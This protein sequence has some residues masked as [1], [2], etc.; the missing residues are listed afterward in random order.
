MKSN[1]KTDT[2]RCPIDPENLFNLREIVKNVKPLNDFIGDIAQFSLV[3]DTNYI[4]GDLIW[5]T[6]K[7]KYPT[8]KT[9]VQEC[10]LAG[11]FIVFCTKTVIDEVNE[12][13]AVVA[14]KHGISINLIRKE[15]ELYQSM[16]RVKQ[17][18]NEITDKYNNGVDPDDAPT[19]ALAEQLSAEGILSKDRHINMMGG[20]TISFDFCASARDYSRKATISVTLRI[21]GMYSVVIGVKLF[22]GLYS[23]IKSIA[24]WIEGLPNW[25]KILLIAGILIAFFLAKFREYIFNIINKLISIIKESFPSIFEVLNQIIIILK[26]NEPVAP[27]IN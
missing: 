22:K 13:L 26:E 4:I 10:I 15:W 16:L 25:A 11:T 6:K 5:L 9:E 8:A 19:L 17:P 12:K 18:D 1:K 2:R 24:A 27:I 7:R 3:I 14:N 20:K 23:F 21:G